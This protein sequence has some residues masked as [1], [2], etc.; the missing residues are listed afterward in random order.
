[1]RA[2]MHR[3]GYLPIF[4]LVFGLIL[5]LLNIKFSL[6]LPPPETEPDVRRL[7]WSAREMDLFGQVI[8]LISG[9]F[10]VVIL[11]KQL[12]KENQK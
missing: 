6:L 4:I 9:V 8:V 12:H 11:F 3:F 1:M 10:G 5:S 7:L 2:R